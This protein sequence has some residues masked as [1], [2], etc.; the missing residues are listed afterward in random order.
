MTAVFKPGM[1]ARFAAAVT[2]DT[3]GLVVTAGG[4]QFPAS[5][6]AQSD[7]NNLDDYEEGTWTPSDASGASLV[8][9]TVNGTY[10]KIGRLWIARCYLTFPSTVNGSNAVIGGLPFTVAN[11]NSARTAFIAYSDESTLLRA[12]A[13]NNGTSVELVNAAG[14][15]ITNAT[16]SLNAVALCVVS[17]V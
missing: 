11:T 6:S 13:I 16:M 4:I 10:E 15:N 5:Q 1:G 3:G 17:Y 7:P 8:F 12:F 14:S 9:T 2:I